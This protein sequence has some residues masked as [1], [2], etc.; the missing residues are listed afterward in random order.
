MA[1]KVKIHRGDKFLNLNNQVIAA[2]SQD[3]PDLIAWPMGDRGRLRFKLFGHDQEFELAIN[4]FLNSTN[5]LQFVWYRSANHFKF[6]IHD[7]TDCMAVVVSDRT[8][9]RIIKMWPVNEGETLPANW[10]QYPYL[11]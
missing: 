8:R 6:A 7:L 1:Y 2:S 5:K 11:R 4:S 10:W 9:N 3:V